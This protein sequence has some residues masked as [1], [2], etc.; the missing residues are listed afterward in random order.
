MG[1]DDAFFANRRF[2]PGKENMPDV[3]SSAWITKSNEEIRTATPRTGRG[4]DDLCDRASASGAHSC[5]SA[6]LR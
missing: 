5:P 2:S 3:R 4:P 6:I 1:H